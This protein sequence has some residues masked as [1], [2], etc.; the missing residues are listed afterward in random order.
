[1]DLKMNMSLL[2]CLTIGPKK[3]NLGGNSNN[4]GDRYCVCVRWNFIR[5][6]ILEFKKSKS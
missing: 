6:S 5:E 2:N 3:R 1:M 4:P